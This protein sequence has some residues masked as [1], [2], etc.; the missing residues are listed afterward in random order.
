MALA[1]RF[2][3]LA[4]WIEARALTNEVYALASDDPFK[5]DWGLGDQIR[6]AAISTMNNVAEGFDSGSRVEFSRFLRYAARSASEV[7]SCLYV[8]LDRRYV[9]AARFEAVYRR[10]ERVRTFARAL[11]GSLQR[12]RKG[13]DGGCVRERS[14]AYGRTLRINATWM[15]VSSSR[16]TDEPGMHSRTRTPAHANVLTT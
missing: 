3:D 1:R 2:E 4:V 16:S 5:R 14:P 7:Q 12:P 10:A 6:R 15:R 13:D 11:I 8:A 9:G